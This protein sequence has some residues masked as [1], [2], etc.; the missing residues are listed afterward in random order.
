MPPAFR[1]AGRKWQI[2]GAWLALS[3]ALILCLARP[4]PAMWPVEAFGMALAITTLPA[5]AMA[6]AWRKKES[7]SWGTAAG[8]IVVWL[9]FLIAA[10][11]T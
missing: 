5:V 7:I 9:F 8:P 3:Y 6:L 2:T 4:A 1:V 11:R 10:V